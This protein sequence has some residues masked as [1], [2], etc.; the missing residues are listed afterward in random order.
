M[1]PAGISKNDW[2]YVAQPIFVPFLLQRSPAV[3][4]LCG[5]NI[6]VRVISA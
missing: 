3:L 2:A 1:V 4:L 5:L 6:R